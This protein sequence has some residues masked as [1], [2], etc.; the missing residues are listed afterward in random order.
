MSEKISY[1]G[2]DNNDCI[3]E[4]NGIRE[5]ILTMNH[6]QLEA[7]FNVATGIYLNST[8]AP[9]ISNSAMKIM[10]D[11][12]YRQCGGCEY[13]LRRIA[14]K[15]DRTVTDEFDSFDGYGSED[16][17]FLFDEI[18]SIHNYFRD[19]F[20]SSED[21]ISNSIRPIKTVETRFGN[22]IES[23]NLRVRLFLKECDDETRDKFIFAS[24][25]YEDPY[26]YIDAALVCEQYNFD[27]ISDY[28]DHLSKNNSKQS[29]ELARQ[30][31]SLHVLFLPPT[32]APT[33][34]RNE[35]S[36]GFPEPSF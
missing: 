8:S 6:G 32:L 7:A 22:I 34:K 4:L 17:S 26:S 10:D 35:K 31:G 16:R 18:S 14:E 30:F 27:S 28:F 2:L 5:N 13:A 23:P 29:L 20:N 15:I 25:F 12:E 11:I 3:D 36:N 33:E 21:K 24:S 1:H 9:E 19:L